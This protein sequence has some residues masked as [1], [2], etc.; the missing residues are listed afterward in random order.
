M[1]RLGTLE[2]RLW[3]RVDKTGDCWNWTGPLHSS[4]YGL[5]GEGGGQGRTLRVHRVA[6]EL[7]VGPIPIGLTLDHLCQNTVCVNPDHLEPVTAE[8][9][10]RRAAARRTTCRRGHA[11]T[12][13]NTIVRPHGRECRTCRKARRR[14]REAAA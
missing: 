4:G 6:Y 9:N 1:S 14:I 2:Q 12:T 5:I 7:L 8:E 3:R 10:L 11:F 13:E